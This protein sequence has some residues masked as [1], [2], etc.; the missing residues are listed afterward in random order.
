MVDLVGA[1]IELSVPG[2][3]R[4]DAPLQ[5]EVKLIDLRGRTVR[6]LYSGG[7][8]RDVTSVAWDGR[9]DA[10]QQL[11]AGIYFLRLTTPLGVSTTRIVQFR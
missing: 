8:V 7:L 4:F 10:R 3:S 6:V 2:S 9:D 5:A 11:A 1:R